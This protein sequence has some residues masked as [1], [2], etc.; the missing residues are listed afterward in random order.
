MSIIESLL[1]DE[2]S[3]ERL[4]ELFT[5]KEGSEVM[6]KMLSSP[7]FRQV[8]KDGIEEQTSTGKV[9]EEGLVQRLQT[10]IHQGE[11]EL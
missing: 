9:D 5:T 3:K 2:G 10:L 4:K 1:P 6:I 7:A 11:L 8:I